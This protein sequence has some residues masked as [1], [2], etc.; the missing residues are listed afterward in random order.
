MKPSQADE[1]VRAAQ[2]TGE[3][4]HDRTGVAYAD[5]VAPEPAPHHEIVR[6]RSRTFRTWL[7]GRYWRANGRPAGGQA[8][9]DAIDVL[10]SLAQFEG[11][12]KPVGLRIALH[13]GAIYLDLAD[14][15]WRV[16]EVDMEGWRILDRSPIPFR[17]PRGMLPLPE[18]VDG[19][20]LEELR[21]F[22][23]VADDDQY[24]LLAGWLIGAFRYAGPYM[25]LVLTGEQDSAKSTTARLLRRLID[26]NEV[27][28]RTLPRD[29]QSMV[30]AANNSWIASWD[31]VSNLQDWQSDAIARLATGAGFGTRMLYSD[32][33][34]VLIHVARPVI[35][36]GIGGIITRPDLMDRSIVVDLAAIPDD[37]RRPEDEFYASLKAAQPKLLGALLRAVSGA[38][39]REERVVIKRLPRMADAAR[40]ITA[41]EGVLRWPERSFL[42]AY[43]S[44]RTNSRAL[45]LEA[46]P[47]TTPINLLMAGADEWTG[48]ATELLAALEGKVEEVVVKRRDWPKTARLLAIELRRLAPD[49]RKVEQ[50]D[51]IFPRSHKSGRQ[52]SL[53]RVRDLSSPSSPPSPEKAKGD[54]GDAGDAG[55]HTRTNG[56]PRRCPACNHP[57]PARTTCD[58]C[59]ACAVGV[60]A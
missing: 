28:D 3:L 57:H 58:Q 23:N 50:V 33:E 45:T 14:D 49:L 36:N 19:G 25:T 46:S 6:I 30:I 53:V 59:P 52:L 5:V 22:V 56:S 37:K 26:P 2:D 16:V 21:E 1:L 38:F 48:T 27:G 35:L 31:N 18:P 44:N 40:W 24:R 39:A 43:S 20:S 29:E 13:K 51:V 8:L 11:A 7:A 15:R 32:D 60:P 10:S 4:F 9:T 55:M 47:L 17:R 12:E 34:E 54:A 41:A 42:A